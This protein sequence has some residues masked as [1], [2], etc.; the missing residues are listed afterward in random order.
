MARGDMRD[1][2]W[3]EPVTVTPQGA[4][5]GGEQDIQTNGWNAAVL[6]QE[7]ELQA[8]DD[9]E[10]RQYGEKMMAD[11]GNLVMQDQQKRTE[12]RRMKDATLSTMM[13]QARNGD[14]FVPRA[15]LEAA[16]ANM[17]FDVAGGNFDKKG[18]FIVYSH[19]QNGNMVPVA[20]ASPE[21][22][23]QT[24]SRAKMGLDYQ[25][26]IY[27]NNLTKRYTREQL[28]KFGFTNP[29]APQTVG[30]TTISGSTARRVFGMGGP[31]RRGISSFSA[32]GKG[33][34]SRT[35]TGPDGVTARED[36]GTREPNGK[37][38]WKQISVGADPKSNDGTQIRR[39]ENSQTGEVVSVRDGETPPW[40]RPATSEKERI[41]KMN[42]DSR[43]AIQKSKSETAQKVAETSAQAT[44]E[45]A[46]RSYDS[47]VARLDAAKAKKQALSA[48]DLRVLSDI[49]KNY[50]LPEEAR[51][52][53]VDKLVSLLSEEEKPTEGA[54]GEKPAENP[55]AQPGKKTSSGCEAKKKLSYNDLK[56]GQTFV[57]KGKDGQRHK[58]RK[59][60]TGYERID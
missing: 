25:R 47:A 20:I 19:D 38:Q 59:T 46:Q 30:S 37:G 23:F 7:R 42:N 56:P 22:Q 16:S 18:N 44:V 10:T 41:A 60:E 15:V 9:E 50:A 3:N 14:G 39:Y 2:G 35:Q 52:A 57:A 11:F 33:G 36:F 26:E 55:A 45:K 17:G 13:L 34:F 51:N 43:E 54:E 31:E 8:R 21:M 24:L 29:D 6:E 58:F 48:S 53:A 32:D 28:D 5:P 49:G 27:G 4:E 1:A 12:I 40:E